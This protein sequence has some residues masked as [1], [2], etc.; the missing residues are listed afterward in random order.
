MKRLVRLTLSLSFL[1][2]IA[3][4]CHAQTQAEEAAIPFRISSFDTPFAMQGEFEGEYRIL[5]DS[6][7]ILIKKAV[8]RVGTH[9]P[10][11][12]RRRLGAITFG[13][14]MATGEKSW[15][16]STVSPPYIVERV[17]TPGDQ[18]EFGAIYFSIPRYADLDL[19]KQWLLVQMSDLVMDM[20]DGKP[21]EAYAFAHSCRDIFYG[22]K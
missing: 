20:P 3:S 5:P 19:Q 15:K 8:V 10:Y 7:E 6:I 2:A 12:G 22:K 17:L 11:K 16:R 1:I 4:V 18:I 9:C 13:L 14:A 21:M